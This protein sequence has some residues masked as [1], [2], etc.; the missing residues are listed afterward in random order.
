MQKIHQLSPQLISKIA[1]GEVIERPVYAIKELV[2][3]SLDAGADTI[4]VHIEESGLK[5]ITVIDNGEGMDAQDLLECFKAH[6]TS[7]ISQ[8]DELSHINTLGFR[9]EALSSIAAISWM[10]IKSKTAQSTAGTSVVLKENTFEKSAPVGM[11]V[12]TTV[13]VEHLFHS[14]PGR[15]KFLR[16]SQTEFRHIVDLISKYVLS[17]PQ[18]HFVLTHNNRTILDF[19]KTTDP[20]YRLEK[21]LGKDVFMSLIPV[22]FQ[23]TYITIT[24]FLAKPSFITRTPSKQFLF[25]NNRLISDKN[26]SLAIKSAYGSML[27]ST[28][29]PICILSFSLPFEMVD[30]NVHPRKEQV[31][32]AD[33]NLLLDAIKRAIMR[34]FAKHDLTK[35]TSYWQSDVLFDGIGLQD[36]V[37]ST[38]SYAGK[39]L[40]EKSMPWELPLMKPDTSQV[41]QIHK[42]YLLVPMGVGLIIIDQHAAHERIL[43][44]QLLTEFSRE[45]RKQK[46][47]HFSKPHVFALS[48]SDSELLQEHL[49]VLQ[50]L[51]W[52]I[53]HFKGTSF[54]LRSM[55]A[56]FKDRDY[57]KL[58]RE[59]LEDIREDAH[60]QSLDSISRRMI[61]YLAC[62]GAVKAGDRLTKKQ[63]KALVEQ[64]EKIPNKSTCPHGRPTK[65]AIDLE[66]MNKLFKRK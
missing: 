51:G 17:Y 48:L 50:Q 1:A 34:T 46:L 24:G 3:N 29:Y 6:T 2:E 42:L 55:P 60:P 39:L 11:P 53:E 9:G 14:V 57:V 62:R 12:G 44:E 23:D 21:L 52:E 32:F 5:S 4:T 8:V 30:V 7:K 16:T 59:I 28:V 18:V 40:K 13:T 54:L 33:T 37:G 56:L 38:D 41:M 43:Y 49:S 65:V 63:A 64:L 19:P 31:R 61:S 20:L 45:K 10:T 26:L 22:T 35:Q 58:L 27:A 36:A 47:F 25:V 66:K 15:K